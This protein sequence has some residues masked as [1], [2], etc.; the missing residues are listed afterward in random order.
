[1]ITEQAW[2]LPL[3]R[4]CY[5][6]KIKIDLQEVT[7]LPL[8]LIFSETSAA[9]LRGHTVAIALI[10]YSLIGIVYNVDSPSLL[11]EIEADLGAKTALIYGGISVLA[12]IWCYSANTMDF[13]MMFLFRI[14]I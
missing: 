1:M 4:K 13:C 12:C 6:L 14:A 9:R 3:N 11:N 7:L 10:A 2:I 5:P 8:S